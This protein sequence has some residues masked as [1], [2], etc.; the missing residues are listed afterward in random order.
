MNGQKG[1]MGN[2]K[3]QIAIE[4]LILAGFVTFI[5][6]GMLAVAFMYSN[7]IKDR[8]RLIQIENFA[9]KVISTSESVFYSGSPSKATISIYLPEGVNQIE[10][11][12]NNLI[13]TAETSNGLTKTAFPSK[14]PIS[15]NLNSAQGIK[16][17]KVIAEQDRAVISPV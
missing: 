4:Y 12:E 5:L 6:I 10:I 11:L 15:G 14:V 17:I 13:V 8:I 16:N 7:T 3:G 2:L 1:K 9:N